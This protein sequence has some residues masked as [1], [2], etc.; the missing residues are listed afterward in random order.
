MSTCQFLAREASRPADQSVST[1]PESSSSLETIPSESKVVVDRPR[2]QRQQSRHSK[3]SKSSGEKR[4]NPASS[5]PSPM[6]QQ[7]VEMGF[8]RSRVEYALKELGEESEEPRA[9][10]IVSWLLDHPDVEVYFDA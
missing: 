5:V 2:P 3:K 1:Q 4:R 6:V 9:E 8:Q 10:L 7:M